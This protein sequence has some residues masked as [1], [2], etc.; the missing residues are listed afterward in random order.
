MDIRMKLSHLAGW[1]LLSLLLGVVH[2]S[3]TGYGDSCTSSSECLGGLVCTGGTCRTKEYNSGNGGYSSNGNSN[4]GGSQCDNASNTCSGY[5]NQCGNSISQAP[6]YCAAAC[7]CHQCGQSCEASNR[8]NAA[9]L[10]TQCF[11]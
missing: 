6:C 9:S 4:S 7:I 3:C 11:Y 2:A 10:G 1:P 8:Q 5:S